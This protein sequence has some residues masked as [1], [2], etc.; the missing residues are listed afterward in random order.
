M[1][2]QALTS[3]L[4][5]NPQIKRLYQQAQLLQNIR[6]RLQPLL[7]A[8]LA[9]HCQL[10]AFS[11]GILTLHTDSSAWASR[12]RFSSAEIL[13]A[14]QNDTALSLVKTI[15]VRVNPPAPAGDNS[16]TDA[17]GT[18][19]SPET[20]HLLRE[21]AESIQDSGLRATLLRLSQNR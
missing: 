13:K 17:V 15:R 10:A 18:T 7:P 2:A 3:I 6:I 20:R 14:C 4:L 11:D 12:L 19:L 1:S 9:D 21:A 16:P 5:S 8:T